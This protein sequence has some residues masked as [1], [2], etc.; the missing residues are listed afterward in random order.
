MYRGQ[1]TVGRFIASLAPHLAMRLVTP[2]FLFL[3]RFKQFSS[4]F[5]KHFSRNFLS[6]SS[7]HLS[8]FP[9][10][11]PFIPGTACFYNHPEQ[12]PPGRFIVALPPHLF[13][14]APGAGNGPGCNTYWEVKCVGTLERIANGQ[15]NGIAGDACATGRSIIVKGGDLCPVSLI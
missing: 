2:L 3:F 15:Y 11:L 8:L 14:A 12:N 5:F 7:K 6:C 1:N 10:H 9:E 4:V 13:G